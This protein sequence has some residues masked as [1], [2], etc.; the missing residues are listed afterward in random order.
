MV[1]I[2]TDVLDSVAR[3]PAMWLLTIV[4]A[5]VACRMIYNIGYAMGQVAGL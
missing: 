5:V 3:Y 4:A 2:T 1:D